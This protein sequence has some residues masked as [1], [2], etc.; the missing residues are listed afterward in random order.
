MKRVKDA[1]PSELAA[2]HSLAEFASVIA[3]LRLL[4]WLRRCRQSEGR[5][6]AVVF[7]CPLRMHASS[8]DGF[9][10]QPAVV[11]GVL[12]AFAAVVADKAAHARSAFS[13]S[14]VAA[15]AA[16]EIVAIAKIPRA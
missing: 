7:A 9:Y 5:Q 14:E 10:D 3:D 1:S 4:E 11:G 6:V 15:N 16:V 12:E 8:A 2:I 13:H